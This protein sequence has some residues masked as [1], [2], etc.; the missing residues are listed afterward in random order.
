MINLFATDFHV[1]TKTGIKIDIPINAK[2][3]IISG[4]S[5][6]GKTKM[7]NTLSSLLQ[8]HEI[9]ESS[10]D[11]DDIIVV[12]DMQS[13]KLLLHASY[14]YKVIFMD[15]FDLTNF[16]ESIPFIENSKNWFVLCAHRQL[17]SCGWD[18]DSI[19]EMHHN[20]KEYELTPIK[21]E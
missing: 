18:K 19:L 15:K 20:G 13:Y 17:P 3:T 2:V 21:L 12:K 4:D 11:N 10:V 8:T 5:A 9:I 14:E 1:K 7:I 6:T 16:K